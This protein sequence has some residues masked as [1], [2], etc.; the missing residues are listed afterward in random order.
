[1]NDNENNDAVGGSSV[2]TSISECVHLRPQETQ[3]APTRENQTSKY[4][5]RRLVRFRRFWFL[6]TAIFGIVYATYDIRPANAQSVAST[7]ALTPG[8]ASTPVWVVGG[9]LTV[10]DSA[11]GTL[12]LTGGGTV[13]NEFGIIGN[14]G[15]TGTVTVSGGDTLGN[16]S[17][18]TSSSPILVGN[19]GTGIV[20]INGGGLVRSD[21]GLIGNDGGTGPGIG[22]VTVSG[23]D[24]SGRA[25]TWAAGNNIY[26][27]FS[28][29]GTLN[30]LDGGVVTTS[31]PGGGNAAGYVGYLAGSTGTVNIS[32][33]TG[34]VST[35][36]IR[37]FL[38]VGE[39]G[40][41][42]VNID[43]GGLIHVGSNVVVARAST[44][45]GTLNLLGDA[46]GRG[47]L[48]T[49]SV[50][51]G[52]GVVATLNLNG[53]ILR[54][55]RNE[56][57]FLNGFG[58]LTVGT[59]GAWFDSNTFSINISTVFTGTSSF[60][61]LGLGTLTLTGNSATFTGNTVVQAGTLQVD[62]V[63]GGT[64]NVSSA[65]RLTGTGQVGTT[66]NLGMI[67]PGHTG[68]FGTLTIA[69]NYIPLGGGLEIKTQLGNDSS[70][71]DRLVVTGT[72]AGATPVTIVN[73]GG[74]GAPTQQGIQIVQV[75]G[76]SNGQFNLANG[77]YVIGGQSALI[78]GAY[79]YVLQKDLAD[80]DWYLRSSLLAAGIS[81]G[82]NGPLYQ[83][84]VPVYEAYANTLLAL[85]NVP[86]LRQRV[87][88]RYYDAA[89]RAHDGVWARVEGKTSHLRPPVSTSA[90]RQ[91]IDSW[92]A[93]FGVDRVLSGEKDGARV[94]GGLTARYGTADTQVASIY[95]D[96][97]IDTKAYGVGTT[98][99][100]YGQHGAY[101]DAQ[102]QAT[103]FSSD[104]SSRLAGIL[105]RGQVGHSYAMSV[106][107][108]VALPVTAGFS[109][110]PQAQLSYVSSSFG[111][112]DRFAAQVDSNKGESLQ[113]RLGL[114]F[115]YQTNS[116]DATGQTRRLNLYS[117]INLKRE[118]LDGT[119]VTVSGAPFDTRQGRTW[120]GVGVGGDYACGERCSV[121]G[122]VAADSDLKGSYSVSATAGFKMRF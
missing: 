44:S 89:D 12:T 87:G 108:G 68:S 115:D 86:T 63:L 4:N 35:W 28:N 116:P 73:V 70:P 107:G 119:R 78:A 114:A 105:V 25:S 23:R 49:G 67:A 83:P 32:S 92:Q 36:T 54:A 57:N 9:D 120:A 45:S 100:W 17:T 101:V 26:V 75:N 79:G 84:G 11:N 16:P 34:D 85:S 59:E 99:T 97:N 15:G 13:S 41:G 18:W 39:A 20:L 19:S 2:V 81:G 113:G 7:G 69:G 76:A 77:N 33:G 93:Q 104:L 95:G 64:T 50:I 42:T 65:G 88:N 31:L 72:T 110:I 52:S 80:G 74:L 47:V 6:P 10:G 111:F 37:D 98:L 24:V 102:A 112:K 40:T 61:K 118:L 38:S 71:T 103:W 66:T 22:T 122:E 60:N 109:I 62:G 58:V 90:I 82:G 51:K 91:D 96:G 29:T 48:E 27:G 1:M 55:T 106:E 14:D 5:N 3:C 94:V 117:L 53:G 8:P 21:Q 46:S 56:T 43:K 30:I 121:Y